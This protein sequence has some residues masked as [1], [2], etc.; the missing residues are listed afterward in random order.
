MSDQHR[1]SDR[2]SDPDNSLSRCLS[3]L[4]VFKVG[5]HQLRSL[6]INTPINLLAF[7]IEYR[8]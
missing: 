7:D 1:H 2:H 3:G 8:T 6:N 4:R 5:T